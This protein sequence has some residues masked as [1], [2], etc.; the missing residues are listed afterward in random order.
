ME[1]D[2]DLIKK[3]LLEIEKKDTIHSSGMSLPNV[4]TED[5]VFHCLILEE[6][7]FTSGGRN[8]TTRYGVGYMPGR[9]TWKGCEFL[10][11]IRDDDRFEKIKDTI[12]Q[13][14]SVPLDML[15]TIVQSWIQ[16]Q[17]LS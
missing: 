5:F 11:S 15:K 13:Y 17:V 14:G 7:E 8:I 6:A 2:L 10:D 16:S 1:R 9:L 3:I 4:R 12:K